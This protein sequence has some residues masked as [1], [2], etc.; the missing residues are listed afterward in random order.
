MLW[1][2]RLLSSEGDSLFPHREGSA[3]NTE[4]L[5]ARQ[6][7]CRCCKLAGSSAKD[8]SVYC[9]WVQ[10]LSRGVIRSRA[11]QLLCISRSL[12]ILNFS[13]RQALLVLVSLSL[14][15]LSRSQI[16]CEYHWFRHCRCLCSRFRSSI[17]YISLLSRSQT[18]CDYHWC[19]SRA[20]SR[21]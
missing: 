8:G 15:Q 21:Q 1:I 18:S 20:P 13:F 12:K 10:A 17:K 6:S 19:R 11:S 5:K 14:T 16:G 4:A 2:Q 9:R 7:H 3:R